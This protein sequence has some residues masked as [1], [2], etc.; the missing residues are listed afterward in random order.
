VSAPDKHLSQ[1][2]IA[3][4]LANLSPGRAADLADIAERLEGLPTKAEEN[5]GL[6]C[7]DCGRAQ[8]RIDIQMHDGA[9]FVRLAEKVESVKGLRGLSSL[10]R[11]F[12]DSLPAPE[13]KKRPGTRKARS[14]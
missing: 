13:P 1:A 14:K 8:K 6:S 7:P 3:A 2:R 5:T 4:S 10:L 9:L 12:E 11:M